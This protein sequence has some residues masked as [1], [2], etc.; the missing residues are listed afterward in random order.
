M[1]RYES[2]IFLHDVL[3]QN[4]LEF[5]ISVSRK[6]FSLKWLTFPSRSKSSIEFS[7]IQALK[8]TTDGS[9]RKIRLIIKQNRKHMGVSTTL[10]ESEEITSCT[11]VNKRLHFYYYIIL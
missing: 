6:K 11:I 9:L 2:R 3:I 5:I 7:H 4:P 8:N 10:K 1:G